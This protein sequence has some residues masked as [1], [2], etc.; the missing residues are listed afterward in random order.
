MKKTLLTAACTL[1]LSTALANA[2]PSEGKGSPA[3]TGQTANPTVTSPTGLANQA[4]MTT[5]AATNPS[6]PS[7]P[8]APVPNEVISKPPADGAAPA[9]R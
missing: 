1:L 2:Q 4:P 9:G 7:A 5:G 6:T 8:N 3:M